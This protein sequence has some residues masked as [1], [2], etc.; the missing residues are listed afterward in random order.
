MLARLR[1]LDGHSELRD[2]LRV[3]AKR[4][5]Q[6]AGIPMPLDGERL[7]IEPTYPHAQA[8][9]AMGVAH[10][11]TEVREDAERRFKGRIRS[12][13]FSSHRR[14]TIVIFEREDGRV[15]WGIAPAPHPMGMAL[16]TLNCSDAWGIEQEAKALQLLAGLLKHRAFKAYLLAGMFIE[17][18]KRSGIT[19]IFRKLRPTIA[20]HV[21]QNS[22]EIMC[23]LCAHPIGYYADSWAGAMCPTDEIVAHLQL[24]RADEA[25]FWKVCNQHP[26]LSPLAG[27]Y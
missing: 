10:T 7:V 19:Y 13:F 21:V 5:Q 9:M 24:M 14:A 6:W 16:T 26:A 12:S 27:V 11:D 20:T 8:L 1:E 17:T 18:S 2:K 23:A 15:D 3:I 25:R 4:D 22:V